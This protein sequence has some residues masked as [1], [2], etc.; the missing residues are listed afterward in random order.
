MPGS[1]PLDGCRAIGSTAYQ[2][3]VSSPS[4]TGIYRKSEQTLRARIV[5]SRGK[6]LESVI[7]QDR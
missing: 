3:R 6:G 1:G 4:S 7:A 5:S 2:T